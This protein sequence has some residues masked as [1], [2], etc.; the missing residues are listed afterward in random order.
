MSSVACQAEGQHNQAAAW[1]QL[2][3]SKKAIYGGFLSNCSVMDSSHCC[4]SQLGASVSTSP[5][6]PS[7][8]ASDDSTQ[9]YALSCWLLICCQG[10]PTPYYGDDICRFEDG[11][12]LPLPTISTRN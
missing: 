11:P 4:Q 3:L 12:P 8:A 6:P 9:S 1:V 10:R 2:N 7:G 5:P